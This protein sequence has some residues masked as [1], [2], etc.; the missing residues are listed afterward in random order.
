MTWQ[1][2]VYSGHLMTHIMNS[3]V[4]ELHE[5]VILHPLNALDATYIKE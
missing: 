5:N 4:T 1:N 3:S 2:I